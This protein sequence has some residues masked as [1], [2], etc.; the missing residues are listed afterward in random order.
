MYLDLTPWFHNTTK[1]VR[2]GVYQVSIGGPDR[3]VIFEYSYWDGEWW[4]AR[5]SSKAKAYNFFKDDKRLGN[6]ACNQF[7]YWRGV[8]NDN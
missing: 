7:I 5:Y 4:Y 8:F 1:P 6:K 3:H 2:P